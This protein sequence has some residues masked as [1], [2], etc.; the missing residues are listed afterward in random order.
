TGLPADRDAHAG[1]AGL[2]GDRDAHA[3]LETRVRMHAMLAGGMPPANVAAKLVDAVRAG[4]RYLLTDHDWDPRILE[5]HESIM[6][7]ATGP[8]APAS[9]GGFRA[10]IPPAEHGNGAADG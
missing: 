6:A 4:T 1:P 5:R 8:P 2:R 9:S 10:V 3:G 7:K